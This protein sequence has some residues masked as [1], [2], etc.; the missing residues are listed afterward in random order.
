MQC[1]ILKA[2]LELDFFAFD[3]ARDNS[4]VPRPHLIEAS[5]L[6]FA[7]QCDITDPGE[8]VCLVRNI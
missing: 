4:A 1:S 8:K 3:T 6:P 2:Q 7:E 5:Q